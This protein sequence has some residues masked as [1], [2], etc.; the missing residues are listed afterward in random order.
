MILNCTF[1]GHFRN[2]HRKMATCLF[3]DVIIYPSFIN[4]SPSM[5]M[6]MD[7]GVRLEALPVI[8]SPRHDLVFPNTS[9]THLLFIWLSGKVCSC[10]RLEPLNVCL[11]T[12]SW[13]LDVM[14][15]Q[16]LLLNITLIYS[17]YVITF[18]I[19]HSFSKKKDIFPVSCFC[20]KWSEQFKYRIV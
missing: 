19:D 2:F 13:W 10:S 17:V 3:S 16:V 11:Q 4:Q 5:D 14:Q 1:N 20:F 18:K 12:V 8:H 15:L 7:S 6:W 9:K